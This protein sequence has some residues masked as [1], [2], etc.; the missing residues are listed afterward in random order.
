MKNYQESK[1]NRLKI[2]IIDHTDASRY[3]CVSARLELIKGLSNLS[4]AK[5]IISNSKKVNNPNN[6]IYFKVPQNPVL[7]IFLFNLKLMY[8]LFK[9]II[10]EKPD[11]IVTEYFSIFGS[12]PFMIYSKLFNKKPRFVLDIRSVPVELK[13]L[14][15]L[16]QKLQYDLSILF[17]KYF[18]EGITFITQGLADEEIK[19]FKLQNKPYT[20]RSSGVN[21]EFFNPKVRYP[22]LKSKLGLKNKFII[23]HHGILLK[24]KGIIETV[25]AISLLKKDYP[26]IIFFILGKG[27]AEEEINIL[28]KK[29][30]L[31]K[32]VKLLGLIPYKEIPKYINM[33]DIG[34]H[35]HPNHQW[36][37]NQ[38]PIK[39]ME[40]LS[41]EKPIILTDIPANVNV[42][43]NAHC[44]FYIKSHNP[45]DIKEGIIRAYKN[46]NKLKS[47]GKIGRKI[48][49]KR[50]TWNK[51]SGDFEKFLIGVNKNER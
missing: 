35:V 22:D 40:Y 37:N 32:Q 12:I 34:I 1:K 15:G 36:W 38:S 5:I 27:P 24:N 17:S 2:L 50:Y 30:S 3:T 14:L 42:V 44:G 16:M 18:A 31:Q 23:L 25:K 26:N 46:K 9:Y 33:A 7:A 49:L 8:F 4:D 51:I 21:E 39:L 41:M 43:G 11:I 28:I 29:Y 13:G 45:K 10:S 19:R 6:V 48:I 47:L 20:V